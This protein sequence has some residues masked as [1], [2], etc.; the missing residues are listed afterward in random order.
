MMVVADVLQNMRI[1]F[2]YLKYTPLLFYMSH[3]AWIR[4]FVCGEG[5][6]IK[7]NPYDIKNSFWVINCDFVYGYKALS[8]NLEKIEIISLNKPK[9]ISVTCRNLYVEYT[10]CEK[11]NFLKAKERY[12]KHYFYI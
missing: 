2:V 8:D 6:H 12:G 7:N 3:E 1:G 9:N 10:V 4:V 11:E 5:I